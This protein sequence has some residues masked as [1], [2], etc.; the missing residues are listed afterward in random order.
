[1]AIAVGVGGDVLDATTFGDDNAFVR[2]DDEQ[3]DFS[4]GGA[5]AIVV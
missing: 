5:E 4:L 1:M 2:A 3:F